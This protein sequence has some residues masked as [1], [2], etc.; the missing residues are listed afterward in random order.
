[1]EGL[2]PT[3]TPGFHHLGSPAAWKCRPPEE[4]MVN[5][6]S[7]IEKENYSLFGTVY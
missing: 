1:M 7:G 4:Q 3:E 5:S 6:I 2:K